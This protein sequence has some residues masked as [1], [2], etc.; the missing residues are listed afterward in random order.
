MLLNLLM[1]KPDYEAALAQAEQLINKGEKDSFYHAAL[2]YRPFCLNKLG[3]EE[4]ARKLYK[5]ANSF[6]RLATLKDPKAV[7]VYLYRTL[8]MKDLE[9]YDKAL[10]LLEF[11]EGLDAGIAEIY[12]IRAD[13]YQIMGKHAQAEEQKE[14]AYQLKPELKPVD[15]KAGE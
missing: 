8:C 5:E 7:D 9:E 12:T 6:Y 13:I 1:T 4:E 11:L 3:K 10:Q 2:Y 15:S 14:K